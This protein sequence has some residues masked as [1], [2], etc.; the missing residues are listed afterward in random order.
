M[1]YLYKCIL[2][3]SSNQRRGCHASLGVDLGEKNFRINMLQPAGPLEIREM[4]MRI[5]APSLLLNTSVHTP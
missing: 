2:M 5:M 1:E 4:G 3:R